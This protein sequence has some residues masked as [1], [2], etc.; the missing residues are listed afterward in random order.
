[1]QVIFLPRVWMIISFF[2]AWLLIQMGAAFIGNRLPKAFFEKSA[3]FKEFGFE[4][5][6]FYKRVFKVH[7]W[8]KLLP[9]GAAI[10]KNGFRKRRMQSMDKAYVA[11]FIL[12][13]KRA[14]AVHWL[15]ILPFWV[16]GLW[17]PPIVVPMMF[18]YAL[19]VN[20][21]CIIAQRYNRPR[22]ERLL[23]RL[24]RK[25]EDKEAR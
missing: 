7:R 3:L 18:V 25:R 16:F 1:M 5:E 13:S 11:Q 24:E 2:A 10:S 12:E 4:S 19:A 20:L 21:P 9:D 23:E 8:K 15:A 6:A 17:S 14:E 22:L